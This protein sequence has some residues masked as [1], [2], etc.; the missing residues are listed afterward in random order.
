MGGGGVGKGL[1]KKRCLGKASL[2]VEVR[3]GSHREKMK[4]EGHPPSVPV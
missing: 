4:Q 2:V 3:M 1:N